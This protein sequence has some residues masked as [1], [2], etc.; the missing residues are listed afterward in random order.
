M[1]TE[2]IG[3]TVLITGLIMLALWALIYALCIR[4]KQPGQ[5]GAMNGAYYNQQ[6][7]VRFCSKCGKQ[8]MGGSN[9]CIY[10]GNPL[11]PPNSVNQYYPQQG[12]A[13]P[14][15]N[16]FTKLWYGNRTAFIAMFVVATLLVG[17]AVGGVVEQNYDDSHSSYDEDYYNSW[18]SYED[19]DNYGSYQGNGGYSDY[20]VCSVCGGSGIC[21]VCFGRGGI[22]YPTYGQ[23]G[24]GWVECEGCHGNRMCRYCGGTGR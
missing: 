2:V 23:G 1:S 21:Q 15:Q 7:P 24:D 6:V 22:S 12:Y 8:N 10:C 18:N 9:F 14:K 16:F 5:M 20:N 11:A 17:V 4:G 13:M 3:M 19:Y